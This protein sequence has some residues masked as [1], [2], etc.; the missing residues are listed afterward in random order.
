MPGCAR[1]FFAALAA[2]VLSCFP[3]N[4]LSRYARQQPQTG[5][6]HK[7]RAIA[8]IPP[9]RK[10]GRS[11]HLCA[12]QPGRRRSWRQGDAQIRR[13]GRGLRSIKALLA[14]GSCLNASK[15]GATLGRCRQN[16][17]RKYGRQRTSLHA[18]SPLLAKCRDVLRW[19]WPEAQGPNPAELAPWREQPGRQIRPARPKGPQSGTSNR[20]WPDK[21]GLASDKAELHYGGSN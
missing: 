15:F 16:G 8:S 12:R 19:V 11:G 13:P 4:S 5:G 9:R 7:G 10:A 1:D 6:R 18:G 3:A 17:R 2:N 14:A 20:S 21:S